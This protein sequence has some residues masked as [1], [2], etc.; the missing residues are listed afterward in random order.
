MKI[1][2]VENALD[3]VLTALQYAQEEDVL[4]LKYAILH[5]SDGVELILKE[6]LKREHWS[7]LFADMKKANKA[8][9]SN[10]DFKSVDFDDCMERL[11]NVVQI[12]IQPHQRKLLNK[13]RSVRNKLQHFE[14][15]GTRDEVVS[16]LVGTWSV[17]ID[18]LHDNLPDVIENHATTITSIKKLMLENE[19]FIN[20]RIEGLKDTIAEF[21]TKSEAILECPHCLQ[22]TLFVFGLENNPSCLFCRYTDTPEKVAQDWA[23]EFLGPRDPKD[24]YASNPVHLC[25]ECGVTA[26]VKQ[27][28][29]DMNPSSPGWV[30]FSCGYTWGYDEMDCCD[31]CGNPYQ[32]GEEDGGTCDDCWQVRIEKD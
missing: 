14:Y 5:L 8:A 10:G 11:E 32:R 17:L 19:D 24:W 22:E 6:R 29:V 1:T 13:L 3:F 9:F 2:L 12:E 26:L 27:D 28:D 20:T 16:I 4:S 7:L 18:F 15:S 21:K 30:C 31:T 23:W 25:P